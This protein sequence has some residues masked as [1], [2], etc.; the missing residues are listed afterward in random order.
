MAELVGRVLQ[1]KEG[2]PE[3]SHFYW[4]ARVR[5]VSYDAA[6]NAYR[7]S[8]QALDPS[9]THLP[10]TK[11]RYLEERHTEFIINAQSLQRVT[12]PWVEVPD[13]PDTESADE[14]MAHVRP[15]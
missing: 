3:V 8:V 15:E 10:D 1:Y 9:R 13:F 5:V 14:W 11:R 4:G 6:T 7:V 12:V 2:H